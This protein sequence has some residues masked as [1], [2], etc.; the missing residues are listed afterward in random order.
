[1]IGLL[2]AVVALEKGGVPTAEVATPVA[3]VFQPGD[4]TKKIHS[5]TSPPPRSIK[6]KLR[7]LVPLSLMTKDTA[8]AAI[9]ATKDSTTG[10]NY[11]QLFGEKNRAKGRLAVMEVLIAE[12]RVRMKPDA[13]VTL[14]DVTPPLIGKEE[15]VVYGTRKE[16]HRPK[17]TDGN[18]MAVAK[19]DEHTKGKTMKQLMEQIRGTRPIDLGWSSDRP[20]IADGADPQREWG[21]RLQME[22][23]LVMVI[24]RPESN[25][26]AT[27]PPT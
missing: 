22:Q 8:A 16:H 20:M 14:V 25:A 5:I 1:M 15:M 12:L 10:R 7:D 18:H 19:F 4:L 3:D 6:K 13:Q 21:R 11:S 2:P 26:E 9:L 24:W 17:I 27:T 23:G